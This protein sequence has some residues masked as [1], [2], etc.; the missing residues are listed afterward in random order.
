MQSTSQCTFRE[1]MYSNN[2][3]QTPVRRCAH[4]KATASQAEMKFRFVR[5]SSRSM[6]IIKSCEERVGGKRGAEER[7]SVKVERERGKEK[8]G[9]EQN[10]YISGCD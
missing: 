5:T 7:D 9:E 3:P 2:N 1:Q 6:P 8:G 10:T 4:V